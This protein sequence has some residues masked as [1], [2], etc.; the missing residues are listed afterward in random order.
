M[1]NCA[2]ELA[3]LAHN[4]TLR[5]FPSEEHTAGPEVLAPVLH[6][7]S[8]SLLLPLRLQLSPPASDHLPARSHLSH[9]PLPP[10]QVGE[11]VPPDLLLQTTLDLLTP[12]TGRQMPQ[13]RGH[14]RRHCTA[15]CP[16]VTED[17]VTAGTPDTRI[18]AHPVVAQ[19]GP[20]ARTL[21]QTAL[22][23][24]SLHAGHRAVALQSKPV[25]QALSQDPLGELATDQPTQPSK[26]RTHH[27]R[28][29]AARR[30]VFQ[31]RPQPSRRRS[32]A[33][34][35]SG[36]TADRRNPASPVIWAPRML[37]TRA[38]SVRR[39]L[40]GAPLTRRSGRRRHAANRDLTESQPA[41]DT[42]SMRL[43][44]LR[45][46]NATAAETAQDPASGVGRAEL[47]ETGDAAL[48]NWPPF[49]VPAVAHSATRR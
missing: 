39:R 34:R 28:Q 12:F 8:R 45:H 3:A 44:H 46:P 5:V 47:Q 6:A 37:S 1:L 13:L 11:P 16:P 2:R 9:R 38:K 24:P 49:R 32:A 25:L 41:G 4:F 23:E 48:R 31:T 21:R 36:T 10:H 15:G 26:L 22:H 19:V 33:T 14:R 30:C 27:A 40:L 35:S 18:H 20:A 17:A 7:R 29:P 43:G 42:A